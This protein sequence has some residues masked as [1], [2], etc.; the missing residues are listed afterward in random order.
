[1]CPHGAMAC[2]PVVGQVGCSE[3][4]LVEALIDIFLQYVTCQK[5]R[6]FILV[7]QQCSARPR[8]SANPVIKAAFR[9]NLTF[10]LG[11]GDANAPVTLMC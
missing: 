11:L 3:E 8:V 5:C 10:L 6:F 4:S 1:M 7:T 2:P 9:C